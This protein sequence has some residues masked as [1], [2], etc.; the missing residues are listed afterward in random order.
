MLLW[1]SLR[2]SFSTFKELWVHS[3]QWTGHHTYYVLLFLF[4]IEQKA[5]A[6]NRDKMTNG[7]WKNVSSVC[8]AID[9]LWIPSHDNVIRLLQKKNNKTSSKTMIRNSKSSSETLRREVTLNENAIFYRKLKMKIIIVVIIVFKF[10]KVWKNVLN[11]ISQRFAS[12][13]SSSCSSQFIVYSLLFK[14]EITRN[15]HN[16]HNFRNAEC[17]TAEQS[18]IVFVCTEEMLSLSARF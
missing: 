10:H 13:N 15:S 8:S 1:V 2:Q 9:S 3:A 18:Q 7:K 12:N 11:V 6:E 4:K 16:S 14:I 5:N 17:W